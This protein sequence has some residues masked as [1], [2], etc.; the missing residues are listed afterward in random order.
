MVIPAALPGLPPSGSVLNDLSPKPATVFDLTDVINNKPTDLKADLTFNIGT[1]HVPQAELVQFA[2]ELA[3]PLSAHLVLFLPFQFTADNIP[4]FAGPDPAVGS[5]APPNPAMEL[6]GGGDDL[7]G[8]GS[9][10]EEGVMEDILKNLTALALEVSLTNN[11]GIG[12]YGILRSAMPTAWPSDTEDLGQF[13]LSGKSMVTIP[14]DQL[15]NP[16]SP[17]LEIYLH[18]EFDIKRTLPPEGAMTVNLGVILRTGID[19]T[20]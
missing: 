12:G 19:T 13:G 10:G 14:K 9:G 17:A 1:V 5:P 11:L 2:A 20:F 16:F 8:R 6:I 15:P 3:T 18:G 4:V 7:L